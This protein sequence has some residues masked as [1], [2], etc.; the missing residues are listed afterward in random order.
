MGDDYNC[1]VTMRAGA[2]FVG[3]VLGQA[4]QVNDPCFKPNLPSAVGAALG[5]AYAGTLASA[6]YG[7][8]F[9]PGFTGFWQSGI[10]GLMPATASTL[11]A[12]IGTNVGMSN[13]DCSCTR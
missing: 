2:G 4:Q 5:G 12:V 10:A 13:N 9:G 3:N 6:G 11:G 7:V 1:Q 8:R